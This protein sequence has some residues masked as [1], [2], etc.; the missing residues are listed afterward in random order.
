MYAVGERKF[1][2]LARA[3]EYLK[4]EYARTGVMLGVEP[5]VVLNKNPGYIAYLAKGMKL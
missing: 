3:L 2:R 5:V 4:K 1:R